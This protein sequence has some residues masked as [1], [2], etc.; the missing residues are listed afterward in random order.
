MQAEFE[1]KFPDSEERFQ[2]LLKLLCNAF[3]E[4]MRSQNIENYMELSF[5]CEDGR[6]V[7]ITVRWQDGLTPV[8]K[9]N[10]HLTRL[11][12]EL[13]A[14]NE[15]RLNILQQLDELKARI[16]AAAPAVQAALGWQPPSNE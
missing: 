16:E 1:A 14:A 13:A 15:G 12:A 8:Q 10:Q 9:Y 7:I 2:E 3:Y 6:G 11:R 4:Q 5:K